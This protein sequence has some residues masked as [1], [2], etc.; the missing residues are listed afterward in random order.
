MTAIALVVGDYSGDG[1]S[2]TDV[3]FITSNMDRKAIKEAYSKGSKKL[4][5]D[6]VKTICK[7]YEDSKFPIK[8][9][10]KL[11]I[12][13][14]TLD[15]YHDYQDE[16]DSDFDTEVHVY[17]DDWVQIYLAVVKLGCPSFEYTMMDSNN[18]A[19]NIGGYGLY[20]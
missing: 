4:G 1:H 7:N 10:E 20:Y 12:D 9:L 16:F 18:I 13:Y 19:I 6:I 5:K 2:K 14:T 17:Q 15:G 3:F 8:L 11:G